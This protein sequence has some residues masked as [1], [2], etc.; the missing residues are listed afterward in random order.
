MN[1]YAGVARDLIELFHVRFDPASNATAAERQELETTIKA[2][3]EG[4]LAKVQSLDEDRILRGYLNLITVTLRTN[5]YQ[6]DQAGLLPPT[7]SLKLESKLIEGSPE[8]RP[9]REIW[10]YSPRVEGIH[11]RFAPIARG[12]IRWSDRAQ[13]FRTEVLGLCKAQQVKNT[14]NRARRRKGRISA[15]ADAACRNA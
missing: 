10:V 13:D 4:A 11:L 2:R 1:R 8:P 6:L 5:F 7:L 3:V 14:V 12:G 15:E 9:F